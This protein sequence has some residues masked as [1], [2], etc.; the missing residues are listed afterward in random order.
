MSV[1]PAILQLQR[2]MHPEWNKEVCQG[3]AHS[4]MERV[5]ERISQ[6]M[7][8]AFD[9]L[10]PGL[11]YDGYDRASPKEMLAEVTR[12][13]MSKHFLEM[14]HSD[15][16]MYRFDFLFNNEKLPPRYLFITYGGEPIIRDT[17]YV[18]SPTMT[19]NL[20]SID[21][22][23]I[24]MPVTRSRFTFER[25]GHYFYADGKSVSADTYWARL[26]GKKDDIPTSRY[27]QLMNYIFCRLP[28]TAG[29]KFMGYDVVFGDC[30]SLN[31]ADFPRDQWVICHSSGN[32]P[33]T[34][35]PNFQAPKTWLAIKREQY[36]NV[37]KSVIASFFYILDNCADL[38][39]LTPVNLERTDVWKRVL[40][41]FIWRNADAREAAAEIDA[42]L[43]TLDQYLDELTM[44]KLV[45]ENVFVKDIY[46]LLRYIIQNFAR[47]TI[48]NDPAAVIGKRLSVVDQVTFG[49]V[50]MI[51]RLMFRL[52]HLEGPRLHRQSIIDTFNRNFNQVTMFAL[53]GTEHQEVSILESA[54][55]NK[56]FKTSGIMLRPTRVSD[57]RAG[58]TIDPV[59]VMHHDFFNIHSARMVTKSSP[60]ATG[61]INPN[62]RLGPNNEI[63][64]IEGLEHLSEE[65]K[66]LR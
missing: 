11:V 29:F 63:L 17:Q 9:N 12:Q 38:E 20:F 4:E 54:T 46:E 33:K 14:S 26:H 24:F 16:V 39:Y 2:T 60:T 52:R 32:R 27:P 7:R 28:G 58:D 53:A 48:E 59:A 18:I 47:M 40:T 64:R 5:P 65:F 13:R 43:D 19:D 3:L 10:Q 51:F 56:I 15:M 57:S 41:R 50:K 21:N 55:D 42:H 44:R 22:R 31:S 23:G 35:I 1:D 34:R 6:V 62:V 30:D 61:R 36:D 49:V 37:A 45:L 8:C 66:R 25:E